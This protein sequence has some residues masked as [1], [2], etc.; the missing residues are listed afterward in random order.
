M[1]SL[2]PSYCL[3]KYFILNQLTYEQCLSASGSLAEHGGPS[4]SSLSCE[5]P[6]AFR[7]ITASGRDR[8]RG[9]L[10]NRT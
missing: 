9:P 8:S 5:H 2:V 1:N 7:R 6:C 4:G 3:V 10:R